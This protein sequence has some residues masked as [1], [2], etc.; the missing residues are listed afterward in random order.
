[1]DVSCLRRNRRP[2]GGADWILAGLGALAAALA[3]LVPPAGASPQRPQARPAAGLGVWLTTVDSTVL[4]RPERALE[5]SR[6]LAE[7]GVRRVGIPIYTGGELLWT[8][9]TGRNQLAIPRSASSLADPDLQ[10][11]LRDLRGRGLETVGWLEYGLMAPPAAPWL[12][13]R[14][15]LLLRDRQGRSHWQE[16]GGERR[17]WLSPAV[18][19]VRRVL[20]DLVVDACTRLP[21]DLIQFDDHFA[22]P[23][24][25]GYDP[26]T[27]EAWRRSR[28]GRLDPTP[29]PDAPAWVSWRSGQL[30]TLLAE[31][32]GAMV[33]HCPRVRLS[34]SPH[35]QP[36]SSE[37]FLADWPR[38]V[39][40]KLVDELV[41][42][43]YRDHPMDVEEDLA[44]RSLQE[45]ARRVPLRIALLAGLRTQPK[46]SGTLRSE[47]EL[48]R[49]RGFGGIDLFFYETM[50]TK[51]EAWTTP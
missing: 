43:L 2:G 9:A 38:W 45:A 51:P 11:L 29:D 39:Q 24:E 49:A 50:R 21:L 48:V 34:L 7:R 35:P 20:V 41:V 32:R 26:F 6:W 30:T 1:M 33:R 23:L 18:P 14:E 37:L 8:P 31:I 15:G 46:S 36:I 12:R 25:L 5:A 27:L 4:H 44:E 10:R 17:V 28:W 42:Q 40:R 19:E 47:L 16:F 22:W 13:G 3:V